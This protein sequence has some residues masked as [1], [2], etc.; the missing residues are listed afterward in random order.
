MVSIDA[1]I[2]EVDLSA[3]ALGRLHSSDVPAMKR[4]VD[5]TLASTSGL[6]LSLSLVGPAAQA[7]L[8]VLLKA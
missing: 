8:D 3:D 2:T 5:R 4:F 6:V 7:F 1:S